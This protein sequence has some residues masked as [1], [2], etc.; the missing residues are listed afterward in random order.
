[1][2]WI[3]NAKRAYMGIAVC[4]ILLGIVV[5]AFPKL[6]ALTVCC[7]TGGVILVL[8][9]VKLIGYFSKDMFRL[10]FQFDFAL[11]IV[12][13]LHGCLLLLA[14]QQMVE[15][16]TIVFGLFLVADGA[17]RLQ[18]VHDAR[19]FGIR[20]WWI[21]LVFALLTCA[22]GL[23]LIIDPFS[24]YRARMILFGVSLIIDGIQ[25]FSVVKQTVHVCRAEDENII[26]V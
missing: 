11:G 7:V 5:I 17:F 9:I 15:I 26:D 21:L 13:I 4:M 18:A 24:G 14:P 23:F 3:K 19:R 22:C 12:C 1:M 20:R 25:N 16:G 10:A 2:L 8:G 6:S